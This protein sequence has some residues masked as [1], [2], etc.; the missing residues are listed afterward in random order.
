[1]RVTG[2]GG[3]AVKNFIALIFMHYALHE[4]RDEFKRELLNVSVFH[5]IPIGVF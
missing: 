5:R 4:F 1:M 2:G 3:G